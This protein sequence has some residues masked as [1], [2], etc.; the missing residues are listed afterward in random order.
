MYNRSAQA[1]VRLRNQ[2]VESVYRSGE[3]EAE[4]ESFAHARIAITPRQLIVL[5]AALQNQAH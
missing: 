5:V 2:F 1:C 3:S 4:A